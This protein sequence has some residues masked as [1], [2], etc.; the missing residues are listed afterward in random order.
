VTSVDGVA[1]VQEVL[2]ERVSSFGGGEGWG[3]AR[4][5]PATKWSEFYSRRDKETERNTVDRRPAY[6]PVHFHV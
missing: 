2:E 4:K 5:G 1:H 3:E 6:V